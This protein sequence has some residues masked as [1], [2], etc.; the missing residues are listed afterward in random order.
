MT[1]FYMSSCE[2]S[3]HVDAFDHQDGGR[4]LKKRAGAGSMSMRSIGWK[5][6]TKN[7][8]KGCL[9]EVWILWKCLPLF[10]ASVRVNLF[11]IYIN[12][13]GGVY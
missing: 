6:F 12:R 2:A 11:N 7:T 3:V 5:A 13:M 8:S 1:A 10:E 9:G 4:S